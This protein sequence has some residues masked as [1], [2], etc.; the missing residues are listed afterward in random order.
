MSA[1]VAV[2]SPLMDEL[3]P[4]VVEFSSDEDDAPI[5]VDA[6]VDVATDSDADTDVDG[7]SSCREEALLMRM[8]LYNFMYVK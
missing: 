6:M 3:L 4:R 2:G 7:S 5:V 1:S 8:Y